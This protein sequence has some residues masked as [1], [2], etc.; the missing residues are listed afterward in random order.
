[1]QSIPFGYTL[2]WNMAEQNRTL[3]GL[4]GY[5]YRSQKQKITSASALQADSESTEVR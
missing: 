1:M 5:P 4:F 2:G 3:G